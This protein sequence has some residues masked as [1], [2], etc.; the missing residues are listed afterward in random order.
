MSEHSYL[1]LPS[2]NI[3]GL[4]NNALKFLGVHYG[5]SVEH[6]KRWQSSKLKPFT[7]EHATSFGTIAMQSQENNSL[8]ITKE[9]QFQQSEDCLSLNIYTPNELNHE[10]E[11]LPVM[12][13]IHGG[14][15]QIGSGSMALYN[16]EHLA[17]SANVIVVSINY[18]LGA[19]GFLRLCDISDGAI[20]STGNEGLT[21][22]ITALK[23][24]QQ[25]ISHFGGDENNVTVFGESA[26]AM[27]IACLLASP[28][29]KGLI[30]K[31]I[32][33]S[34]AAH[35]Y[36]S[37][38]KANEV[39]KEFINSATELGFA[40][41]DLSNASIDDLL[42]IQQHFIGRA[43]I[44]QKFGILPFTPVIDGDLL[45]LEPHVA[46]EQGSAKNISILS[47]SNTDEW[48]LFAAMLNQNT[49]S[50]DALNKALSYLM[51]SDLV[52]PC[53][54]LIDKQ[55][56]QRHQHK[57]PQ[58]RLNEA[59]TEY[60]FT[61][62]CHRLLNNHALA[63]GTAFRYKLGRKT[64]IKKLGC[65][66]VTDIG[67][68]FGNVIEN[69]HGNSPRVIELSNQMQSCWANFAHYSTPATNKVDW[70]KY[71][72]DSEYQFLYF[73]HEHNWTAQ[74]DKE[75][76]DFWQQISDQQLASF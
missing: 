14:G 63:G 23:W 22:Q 40:V 39:A 24:V 4:K 42:R 70:P 69:F 65:T 1:K 20:P 66:H 18:R 26:G 13:W 3:K 55:L 33:Q 76:L 36:S 49:Q 73:D 44:Y 75:S 62:P 19:L 67:F 15:F 57:S 68:V 64:V 60:W 74:A 34:G 17:E 9:D 61:Q 7:Q 50:N 47:G 32:L 54:S 10:N 25:N 37:I 21:D 6:S 59:F 53:L 35:T 2:H 58:T 72:P 71:H 28:Y 43:E 56:A 38:D 45:P 5:Y 16:G 46:I 12:V 11:K 31:A 52:K 51:D 41:T 8:L 27:S 30:H 48:T 29:T